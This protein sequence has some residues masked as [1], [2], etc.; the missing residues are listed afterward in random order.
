MN[1]ERDYEKEIDDFF[2][3]ILKL[4]RLIPKL[5][6][7]E[8]Q[9]QMAGKG[10]F[11]QIKGLQKNWAVMVRGLELVPVERL[12]DVDTVCRVKSP[13]VFLEI[14]DRLLL[15]ESSAFERAIQ[16]G[17]VELKGKHTLHDRLLWQKAF[18]RVALARKVYAG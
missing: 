14:C 9:A 17:D 2:S 10:A 1:Q 15:G 8:E 11:F 12:D 7:V 5:S 18:E 3:G 16:R 13:Q 4:S 6:S